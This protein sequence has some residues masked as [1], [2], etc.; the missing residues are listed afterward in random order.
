MS[1]PLKEFQNGTVYY[2]D[3]RDADKP[4]RHEGKVAIYDH[5]VELGAPTPVWVPRELV[6]GVHTV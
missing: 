3:G 5:W 2:Y 6:E 1:D 4:T